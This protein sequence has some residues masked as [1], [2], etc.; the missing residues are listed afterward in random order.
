VQQRS[1][2]A[3]WQRRLAQAIQT[4]LMEK[5][6]R[7]ALAAARLEQLSPRHVLDRG[8]AWVLDAKGCVVRKGTEFAVGE[9]LVIQLAGRRVRVRV[10][11]VEESLLDGDVD[12]ESG[13]G[14][15]E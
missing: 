12:A 14:D 1:H 6:T 4:R 15:I 11:A 8:Y 9:E 13:V 3:Q 10:E 5:N 7:L 2:L